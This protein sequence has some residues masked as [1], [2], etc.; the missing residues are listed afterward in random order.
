MTPP[1]TLDEAAAR[2]VAMKYAVGVVL[3]GAIDRSG[4]GYSISVKAAQPITGN[5]TANASRQASAKD[6][7]LGDGDEA[8]GDG[9]QGAR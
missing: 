8:R 3:S 2:Q 7:V 9:S 4:S 1:D 6:Q 5:V